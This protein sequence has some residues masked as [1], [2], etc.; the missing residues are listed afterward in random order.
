MIER[1]KLL[2]TEK[3]TPVKKTRNRIFRR[4]SGSEWKSG[5]IVTALI[6]CYILCER[7]SKCVVVLNEFRTTACAKLI[8]TDC[9]EYSLEFVVTNSLTKSAYCISIY[10][11][12][13]TV[14]IYTECSIFISPPQDRVWVDIGINQTYLGC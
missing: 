3:E 14:F 8:Y 6:P 5:E 11:F 4:E 1:E 12:Y 9:I 13:I 7:E 2:Y 10:E